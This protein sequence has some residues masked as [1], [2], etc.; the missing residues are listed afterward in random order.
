MSYRVELPV[1]SGP[2]DLLLHLVKQQ[3]VDIREV[4]I[5]S[6]LDAFLE[7][8]DVLAALDLAD[9]GDFVVMAS[10]LMELKSRELLPRED[11]ASE[12]ELDPRDD[13]IRRLLEYKRY[14]D[15]SR[16]L[17][18]MGR[19]RSRQLE[20]RLKMPAELKAAEDEKSLDLGDAGV[21]ALTEAFARLLEETG[22]ETT[23]HVNIDEHG[24]SHFTEKVLDIVKS[25]PEV[26]FEELFDPRDGRIGLISA[27]IAVLELMKQ[28]FLRAH[29]DALSD[30]IMVAYR[31]PAD[32][33]AEEVT[34]MARSAWGDG[35]DKDEEEGPV[36]TS[37][38]EV[39][40]N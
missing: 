30:P 4:S 19:R 5:A 23:L 20:P 26:L 18:Q 3:E 2:L 8:L 14:R 25:K 35:E 15:L 17:E 9:I 12:E 16:R 21:W 31:G 34:T 10:T 6:I 28:G 29:Q 22:G 27:L 33:T 39:T 13:L 40:E 1:F 37:P 24:V 38:E 36:E 7:H 11:L 32:L